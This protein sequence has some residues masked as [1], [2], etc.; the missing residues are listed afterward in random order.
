LIIIRLVTEITNTVAFPAFA[1]LQRQ[2]ERM[3]RAFYNVTQYTSLLAFPV[4]LGLATLAPELVPALFGRQWLPSVPVMQILAMIG[5]LQSVLFFNGTVIRA[6]GKPSWELGIMVLNTVCSVIAFLLVVRSGIVAVAASFVVV[7][8][9]VAPVSFIAV[10]RLIQIDFKTYLRQFAPSL[11]AALIMVAV[12]FGLKYLLRNQALN[13]YL[14]LSIYLLAGVLTYVLV[15]GLTA[16]SL[17][18]EVLGLV[19][20][21]VPVSRR[22]KKTAAQASLQGALPGDEAISPTDG[23]VP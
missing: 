1:R 14:E 7:G 13:R 12:I 6:S 4:F 18:R 20:L 16:R 8:Y 11:S 10:R 15:L 9:M 21:V 23:N 19:G 17:F 22:R 3:R 2:P 5:I